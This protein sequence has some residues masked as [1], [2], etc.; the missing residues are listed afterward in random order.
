MCFY[1][2]LRGDWPNGLRTNL[3]P[4]ALAFRSFSSSASCDSSH[5][6][7]F[8]P[9]TADMNR[10]EIT[11][12][13]PELSQSAIHKLLYYSACRIEAATFQLWL[14]APHWPANWSRCLRSEFISGVA[15]PLVSAKLICSQGYSPPP[16]VGLCHQSHSA[17]CR[18]RLPGVIS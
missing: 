13:L 12:S 17:C 14:T 3:L 10:A 4:R 2:N 6:N 7:A 18:T 9:A 8:Y 1:C 16:S 11:E 15:A 5:P